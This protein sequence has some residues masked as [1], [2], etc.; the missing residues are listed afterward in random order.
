MRFVIDNSVVMR[1]LF[2]DGSLEDIGYPERILEIRK[3]KGK[4]AMAPAIWPPGSRECNCAG[5][6]TK[7]VAGSEKRGI[8]W[9]RSGIAHRN[10]DA[11]DRAR[12]DG[13][14][15]T[16]PSPQPVNLRRFLSRTRP[17]RRFSAGNEQCRLAQ[18]SG[19]NGW[20]ARLKN[21]AP[22]DLFERMLAEQITQSK[23]DLLSANTDSAR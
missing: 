19:Q 10:R 1:W 16:R 15:A 23:I 7:F 13:Y 2:G 14:P 5:R 20:L 21:V 6:S 8:P 12:L 4:M 9:H 11:F 18:G 22:A 3:V 17:A